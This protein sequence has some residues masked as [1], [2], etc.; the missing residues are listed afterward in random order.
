MQAFQDYISLIVTYEP[1]TFKHVIQE[2]VREGNIVR[3]AETLNSHGYDIYGRIIESKDITSIIKSAPAANDLL[4]KE[5]R[6]LYL[7]K[8][9]NY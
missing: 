8:V 7:K 6:R 3:T 5:I 2:Y 4:H 1:Y 9:K